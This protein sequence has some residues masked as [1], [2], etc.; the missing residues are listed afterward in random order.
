VKIGYS[1]KDPERRIKSM[2]TGSPCILELVAIT[3]GGRSGEKKIHRALATHC[4][5]GE[6]FEANDTVLEAIGLFD[7][8]FVNALARLATGE[9]P[10]T[11]SEQISRIRADLVRVYENAVKRNPEVAELL[12]AQRIAEAEKHWSELFGLPSA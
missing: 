10:E 4:C 3:S 1:E 9:L 11:E 5:H 6:W 2:A 12:D 8:I 7:D